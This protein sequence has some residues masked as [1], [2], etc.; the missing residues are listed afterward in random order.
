MRLS[1]S[2]SRRIGLAR[3]G[4]VKAILSNVL[5]KRFDR[6]E[7]GP[8]KHG[9]PK[10]SG[11]LSFSRLTHFRRCALPAR[12]RAAPSRPPRFPQSSCRSRP[13]AHPIARAM[14]G[15][16]SRASPSHDAR[17][18]SVW[19]VCTRRVA[20]STSCPATTT[21]RLTHDHASP[22]SMTGNSRCSPPMRTKFELPPPAVKFPAGTCVIP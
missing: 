3:C 6:V 13:P 22:V 21:L 8:N 5:V 1:P 12:A 15:P 7:P 19:Y 2:A 16:P 20:R 9:A 10:G 17:H 11:P 4:G 14:P 18:E